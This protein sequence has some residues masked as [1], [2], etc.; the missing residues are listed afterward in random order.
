MVATVIKK[1]SSRQLLAALP[2]LV[3][4]LLAAEEEVPCPPYRGPE[5]LTQLFD[6]SVPECG[7]DHSE[8]IE[9][10]RKV[11]LATPRTATPAFVNQ[12]YGGR[13]WPATLAEMLTAVLN[14]SMYTFKVAGLQILIEQ[15]VIA[16]MLRLAGLTRG[17]G[18]FCPGGSISNLVAMLAARHFALP[19][20]REDGLHPS[21]PL[22][23]YASDQAHYSITKNAGILGYGRH[24]VRLIPTDENGRMKTD[25]LT[26]AVA[27]D[28]RSGSVPVLVV[29]TAG[30]TVLGAFDPIPEILEITQRF[31]LWLHVD[32]AL[33]GSFLFHPEHRRRLAGLEAAD[34]VAWNPHKMLG[35]PL[36]ASVVLFARK[37]TLAENLSEAADY[38][39]QE[40]DADLNPGLRS[41][42]CGRRN[43]AFKVWTAMQ[44]LGKDGLRRRVELQLEL[45]RFAAQEISKDPA[46]ELALPPASLTVCFRLR[47]ADSPALAQALNE[48]G[49]AKIS[50]ASF[51]GQTFLRLACVNPDMTEEDLRALLRNV[52][53]A[54]EM[55]R[56]AH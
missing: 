9:L 40:D 34:S 19:E 47:G 41:I 29:A 7:L 22:R 35:V 14:N 37:G 2:E 30:T 36:S 21:A 54:G 27:E 12:L 23:V 10:L 52:K 42:Q 25:L 18:I 56:N 48:H 28:R 43:D 26:A 33:G 51:R 38:L 39:F 11:I 32:A 44:Y 17:E 46:F 50:W 53:Y 45:A 31:G 55:Q 3:A 20:A 4:Q 5:E 15:E 13:L 8:L 49:L 16:E 6:L 24:N 1:E